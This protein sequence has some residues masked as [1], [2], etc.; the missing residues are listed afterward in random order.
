MP[1]MTLSE[2]EQARVSELQQKLD[3]LR[4]I[5]KEIVKELRQLIYKIERI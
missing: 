3:K 2:K 1:I 4:S 5:E